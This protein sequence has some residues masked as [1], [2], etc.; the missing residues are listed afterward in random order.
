MNSFWEQLYKAYKA[1]ERIDIQTGFHGWDNKFLTIK[2]IGTDYILW[3]D[4][5]Y[6]ISN[7]IAF[8]KE[9]DVG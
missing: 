9:K 5:R 4:K 8:R 2:A 1:K 3:D 6:Q 7:I